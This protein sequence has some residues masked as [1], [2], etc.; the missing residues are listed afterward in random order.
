MTLMIV[1]LSQHTNEKD[2]KSIESIIPDQEIDF[3][4]VSSFIR[5]INVF[6]QS[7]HPLILISSVTWDSKWKLQTRNQQK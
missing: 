2:I 6:L 4:S 1:D 7:S 3:K 5:K